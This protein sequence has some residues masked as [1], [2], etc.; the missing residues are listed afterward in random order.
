MPHQQGHLNLLNTPTE[1]EDNTK[2]Q[3]VNVEGKIMDKQGEDRETQEYKS[4]WKL[5]IDIY[6]SSIVSDRRYKNM[7]L[8]FQFNP[9]TTP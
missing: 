3:I 2:E 9:N 7:R 8:H 6:L 5:S 1:T 4:N